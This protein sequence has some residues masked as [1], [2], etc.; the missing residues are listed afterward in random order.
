MP[1]DERTQNGSGPGFDDRHGNGSH[2]RHA[3]GVRPGWPR[4]ASREE[5][6]L[7]F[8][9]GGR[10]EEALRVGRIAREFIRG[11]RRLHFIGPC[12]TVFGSA[13]FKEDHPY[14]ELARDVGRRL[15]HEGF[16]VMT[17]GGPG[18][19]EAANRG[20]KEAGGLSLGCN[21]ELPMEQRPN[22]YLDHFVDFK[23]FFVRKVMLVKYSCAFVVLPGGFGT[24][25]ELFETATLVQTKKIE[26]F[27]IVLM[28]RSYWQPTISMM[29]DVMVREGTISPD[30]VDLIRITDDPA[31][32]VGLVKTMAC[33]TPSRRPTGVLGERAPTRGTPTPPIPT[34]PITTEGADNGRGV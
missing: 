15:A 28:G 19:M 21:I 9:P 1:D 25:D 23:Y 12:V 7:L 34:G 2:A 32:A 10:V 26:Q 16:A 30:D 6:G 5:R 14:Y 3:N 29:R 17:G 24:L 22:P 33:P 31:E 27:P 4:A 11:F 20:A 18:I 13:R 8:G